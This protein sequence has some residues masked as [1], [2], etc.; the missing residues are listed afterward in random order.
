EPSGTLP[1]LIAVLTIGTVW[2]LQRQGR[3]VPDRLVAR[4]IGIVTIALA[5]LAVWAALTAIGR[6]VQPLPLPV[7]VSAR[8]PRGLFAVAAVLPPGVVAGVLLAAAFGHALPALGSVDTLR[9]VAV[10]LKQPRIHNLQRVAQLVSSFGLLMTAGLSFAF[11][12]LVPPG[13]ASLWR[14]APLVGVALQIV[15]PSWLRLVCVPVVVISAI[16][17]LLAACR[18]ASAGAQTM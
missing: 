6:P 11:V 12:L 8:L 9:H 13:E 3:S 17:F 5:G 15:A 10:D 1:L 4:A 7:P 18:S 14:D 2:W 16:T